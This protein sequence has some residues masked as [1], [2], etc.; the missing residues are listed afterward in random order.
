MEIARKKIKEIEK[1]RDSQV[2]EMEYTRL[3]IIVLHTR[4]SSSD[5]DG[6]QESEKIRRE[7]LFHEISE[8]SQ[9]SALMWANITSTSS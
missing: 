2:I 4:G 5:L 9:V 3:V 7:R 8:E 6:L 1:G